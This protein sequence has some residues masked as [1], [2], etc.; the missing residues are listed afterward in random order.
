VMGTAPEPVLRA[1]P[2]SVLVV[3][4]ATRR[5]AGTAVALEESADGG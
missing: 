3:R 1:C 5:R 2:S 4:A